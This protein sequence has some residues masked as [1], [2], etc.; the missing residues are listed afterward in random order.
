MLKSFSTSTYIE[1][2]SATLV[3]SN[4]S[5]CIQNLINADKVQLVVLCLVRTHIHAGERAIFVLRGDENITV[6]ELIANE[7]SDAEQGRFVTRRK[8]CVSM[9][10]DDV[11]VERAMQTDVTGPVPSITTA[12]LGAYWFETCPFK[13]SRFSS[14]A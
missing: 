6:N 8:A 14:N 2:N 7:G 10:V 13:A 3:L 1:L 9:M 5:E 11:E 12:I 4:K